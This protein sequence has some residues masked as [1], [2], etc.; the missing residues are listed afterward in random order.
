VLA[1]KY[2]NGLT[3]YD[4]LTHLIFN[5]GKSS[6]LNMESATSEI[7]KNKLEI[8]AIIKN[9]FLY[10]IQRESFKLKLNDTR[11]AARWYVDT[12]NGKVAKPEYVNL[13][14]GEISKVMPEIDDNFGG[15]DYNYLT[16]PIISSGNP[17]G[18]AWY[19]YFENILAS[20][21]NP[22]FMKLPEYNDRWDLEGKELLV[23]NKLRVAE[24]INA[25]KNAIDSGWVY[26]EHFL[27]IY[28]KYSPFIELNTL[29]WIYKKSSN[30]SIKNIKNAH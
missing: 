11:I 18:F 19:G 9:L 30:M 8:Y 27:N 5:D 25:Y 13:W 28:Y 10:G 14:T 17:Y 6:E 7:H 23:Q 21:S 1:F 3:L 29:Q 26:D 12:S 24:A 15:I 20:Y 2:E 16:Y 22:S 4:K